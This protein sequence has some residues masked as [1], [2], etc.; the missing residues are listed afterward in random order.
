MLSPFVVKFVIK[1]TLG[2]AEAVTILNLTYTL[3]VPSDIFIWSSH[4][5]GGY[6]LEVEA[7]NFSSGVYIVRLTSGS[8]ILS[9]HLLKK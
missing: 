5:A 6:Q 8:K 3:Q 7:S 9:L 4:E 2:R 1:Y